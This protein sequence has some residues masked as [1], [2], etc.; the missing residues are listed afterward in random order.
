MKYFGKEIKKEVI[1]KSIRPIAYVTCEKCGKKIFPSKFREKQSEY[2]H[3]HTWHSQ[4]GLESIDS[5]EY[6]DYC[7]E[8][9][10]EVVSDYVKNLSRTE[11][12]ELSYE[13]LWDSDT[14]ENYSS[15]EINLAEE[16]Y[17]NA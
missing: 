7:K 8:C 9:A 5:H 14:S 12:L 6:H 16:E 2:V 13:H 10:V 15:D 11:E 17:G 4:W 3:V 1:T